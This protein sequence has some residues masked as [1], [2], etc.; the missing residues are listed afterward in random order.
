MKGQTTTK[1]MAKHE[2]SAVQS[3]AGD[4]STI[5]SKCISMWPSQRINRINGIYRTTG[6]LPVA[7]IKDNQAT[8]ALLERFANMFKGSLSGFVSAI[9]FSTVPS[10]E[11]KLSCQDE[12]RH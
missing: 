8:G 4:H 9:M 10:V 1:P 6:A 7:I 11:I 12:R 2:R 5:V 3:S